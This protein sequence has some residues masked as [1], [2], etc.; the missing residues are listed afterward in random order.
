MRL[1]NAVSSQFRSL[2]EKGIF[3]TQNDHQLV[4]NN[5]NVLWIFIAEE[6]PDSI[7]PMPSTS[8]HGSEYENGTFIIINNNK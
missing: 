5:A 2:R 1:Y 3:I 8:A 4:N 6:Q 7:E